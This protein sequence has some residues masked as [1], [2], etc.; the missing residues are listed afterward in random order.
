MSKPPVTT[1]D[2]STP[3]PYQVRVALTELLGTL[4]PGEPLP[5]ERTLA[6]QFGVSRSTVRQAVTDLVAAGL[7]QRIHG[8]GN[9]PVDP[10]VLLPLRLASYTRDVTEQG[11][12]PTSRIVSLTK[13]AAD[14]PLATSLQIEEGAPVWRLERLRLTDTTPLALE[15]SHL[16]VERFPQLDQQLSDEA[17]L[18]R[19]LED[20]YGIAL[21]RAVQ[22][23]ETG[24]ATPSEY[25]LLEADSAVP[26]LQLTRTTYDQ[27]GQPIE[28]VQSTYRGDRCRLT[29]VLLPQP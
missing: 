12:R 27:N 24:M 19:L 10:K 11:M 16:A 20:E 5:P 18:Y 23:V 28:Y 9:Y 6:A 2:D 7:V 17:S 21:T 22:T 8:S 25:R 3:K 26:V 14:A 1:I 15:R 29:A 4:G 13:E